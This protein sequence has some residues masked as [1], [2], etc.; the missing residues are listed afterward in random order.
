MYH[1]REGSQKVLSR[2]LYGQTINMIHTFI[3]YK[4]EHLPG[5]WKRWVESTITLDKIERIFDTAKGDMSF[6]SQLCRLV[7]E[8]DIL[9]ERLQKHEYD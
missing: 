3:D 5:G 6:V 7:R 2:K 8:Q 1:Q 4:E 9:I